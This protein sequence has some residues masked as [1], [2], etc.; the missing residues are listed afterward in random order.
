MITKSLVINCHNNDL[1]WLF[2]LIDKRKNFSK[3]NIFGKILINRDIDRYKDI[4]QQTN[5]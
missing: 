5:K 3:E 2:K 1:E 4:T